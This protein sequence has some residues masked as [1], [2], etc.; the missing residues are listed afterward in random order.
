MSP[1]QGPSPEMRPV[2]HVC[3]SSRLLCLLSP[4]LWAPSASDRRAWQEAKSAWPGAQ[5]CQRADTVTGR[6]ME[7]PLTTW[8]NNA[9]P[10]S[11]G[12]IYPKKLQ[13]TARTDCRPRG[14]PPPWHPTIPG[15][16][17]GSPD[18]ESQTGRVWVL[19]RIRWGPIV[20][21]GSST[22]L[23]LIPSASQWITFH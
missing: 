3:V 16:F 1:S 14:R 21:D 17:E 22:R 23:S 19:K 7:K 15:R 10:G 18:W 13:G 6:T 11:C 8:W 2:G 4:I 12:V 9:N 5:S 20:P